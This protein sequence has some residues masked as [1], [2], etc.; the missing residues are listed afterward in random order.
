[1]NLKDVDSDKIE[2]LALDATPE[3]MN[4]SL[5]FESFRSEEVLKE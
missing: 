4:V 3:S 2:Q 1:M 5:E